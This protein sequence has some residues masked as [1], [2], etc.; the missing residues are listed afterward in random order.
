MFKLSNPFNNKDPKIR[1]IELEGVTVKVLSKQSYNKLSQPEKNVYDTF[2][3]NSKHGT[4]LKIAEASFLKGQ[5]E[6]R[7]MNVWDAMR[8]VK[9]S[10]VKK[11]SNKP[12]FLVGLQTNFGFDKNKFWNYQKGGKKLGPNFR[13]HANAMTST[14]N[15]PN[16][17][18]NSYSRGLLAESAHMKGY[19]NPNNNIYGWSQN[20]FN[21]QKKYSNKKSHEW[22][23]HSVI[24]PALVKKYTKKL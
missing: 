15:V 14:I 19:F 18:I 6:K 12:S 21:R 4:G 24:Q 2:K 1:P 5:K 7:S 22:Y 11:I 16:R 9:D 23:T 10:G 3:I 13:A 8:L 17:N 20:L